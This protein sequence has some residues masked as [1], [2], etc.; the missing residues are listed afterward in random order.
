S[1]QSPYIRLFYEK[2]KEYGNY[3]REELP[4]PTLD[5][6][7]AAAKEAFRGRGLAW[8]FTR[9]AKPEDVEQLAQ[10]A[11]NES[12]AEIQG[13]LLW[14]FRP[15][16]RY[17]SSYVFPEAF[18]SQLRQ[19]DDGRLRDLAYDLIGQSPTPETRELARS[20]IQSGEDAANGMYLLSK[21]P[22]PEDERLLYDV[23]R[24]YRPRRDT[25]SWH[26]AYGCARDGI[27]TMRGKPKTDILEYLYR[28]TLCGFCR[29]EIVRLMHKKGVLSDEIL[30]ECRFDANEYV[31]E[32]AE[33][34]S[35]YRKRTALAQ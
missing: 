34:I 16:G 24:T 21:N 12:D 33:R 27:K 17:K 3:V 11:M 4:V 25:G 32:F 6:V 15:S 10:A 29:V 19:S 2:T 13:K 1:D 20:L 18:L 5:E 35:R 26:W 31:R 28:N 9:E 23:V 14:A 22:L 30:N 8:R 7:L